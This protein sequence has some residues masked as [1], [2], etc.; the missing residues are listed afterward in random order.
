MKGSLQEQSQ[1]D[2]RPAR[3]CS[4]HIWQVSVHRLLSERVSACSRLIRRHD[5]K[6]RKYYICVYHGR[7]GCSWSCFPQPRWGVMLCLAEIDQCWMISH[8]PHIWTDASWRHYDTVILWRTDPHWSLKTAWPERKH[9][10][11]MLAAIF[12]Q[13]ATKHHKVM[14]NREPLCGCVES[15]A[16]GG[17]WH[18]QDETF[19][20]WS[21][22]EGCVR[23]Q[24]NLFPLFSVLSTEMTLL[25]HES[26]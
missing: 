20:T 7:K 22:H 5:D 14:L 18:L 3:T 25:S 12:I 2:S 8:P 9:I 21:L 19:H 11:G 15:K 10:T 4:S 6:N 17:L 23:A 24:K 13:T 1:C 16:D 26:T